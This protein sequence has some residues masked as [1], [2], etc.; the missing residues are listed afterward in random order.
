MISSSRAT[1]TLPSLAAPHPGCVCCTRSTASA[2][3]V[4]SPDEVGTLTGSPRASADASR[5]VVGLERRG[6]LLHA[7]SELRA[8]HLEVGLR[9]PVGDL[10]RRL[11]EDDA[12]HVELLLDLAEQRRREP[13]GRRRSGSTPRREA[14]APAP[15]RRCAPG[16]RD[17]RSNA[18]RSWRRRARDRR[19]ARP[20]S[21][22]R[23]DAPT[24]ARRR[25]PRRGSARAPRRGTGRRAQERGARHQAL[26]ER[27]EGRR[28]VLRP[29]RRS[30]FQKRRRA[31]RTYQLD[32]SSTKRS[33]RLPAAVAS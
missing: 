31:R 8:E 26:G 4:T 30:A 22:S 15:W 14:G 24:P 3:T 23:P 25:G 2:P 7:G 16:G 12:L 9:P 10:G 13:R 33:I 29:A 20:A 19:L 6:D 27:R 21:G 1:V 17:R 5:A 28:R 18:R 11:G 32:R